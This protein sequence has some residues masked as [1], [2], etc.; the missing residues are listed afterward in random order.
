MAFLTWTSVECHRESCNM[1]QREF[2]V[3]IRFWDIE[4]ECDVENVSF[5]FKFAPA[6]NCFVRLTVNKRASAVHWFIYCI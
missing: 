1:V 4:Y 2:Q 5:M 3:I 6:K